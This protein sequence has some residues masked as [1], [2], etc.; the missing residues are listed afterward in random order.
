MG[1]MLILIA[2]IAVFYFSA[3]IGSQNKETTA[4]AIQANN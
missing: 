2:S 1:F 4:A 3:D